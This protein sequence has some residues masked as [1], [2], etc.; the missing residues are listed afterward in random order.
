MKSLNWKKYSVM[1]PDELRADR[2]SFGFNTLVSDW[3][4][5]GLITQ[6]NLPNLPFNKPYRYDYVGKKHGVNG[7]DLSPVMPYSTYDGCTCWSISGVDEQIL[8]VIIYEGDTCT[9]QRQGVRNIWQFKFNFEWY[10][11]PVFAAVINSQWEWYVH[12]K[13]LEEEEARVNHQLERISH[14]LLAGT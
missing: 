1:S 14:M 5:K 9:G 3:L 13:Y 2:T 6:I 11:D 7:T 8:K 12:K 4:T 10:D